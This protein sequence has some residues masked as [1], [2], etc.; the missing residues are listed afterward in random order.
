MRPDARHI[1]WKQHQ[2]GKVKDVGYVLC[3]EF[4]SDKSRKEFSLNQKNK[5]AAIEKPLFV[6]QEC[7]EMVE[8]HRPNGY[9]MACCHVVKSYPIW[10][11][12]C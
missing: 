7:L 1:L 4:D 8:G 2:G 5:G 11:E 10:S 6:V 3:V 12:C 9:L